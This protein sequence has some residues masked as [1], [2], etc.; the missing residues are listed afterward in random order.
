MSVVHD[1]RSPLAAIHSGAQILNGPQLPEEQV[2]R[3]ARNMYNASIRIQE[4]LQDYLEL[5][6]ASES[7]RLPSN[8][9]GL[10]ADAVRRIAD[11]AEAQSVAVV[12]DVG[13]DL[14]VTVERVRIGSVLANLLVNALEAM[15]AGGSIHIS[16]AIAEHSL[17][18]QIDRVA[19]RPKQVAA[20]EAHCRPAKG[21]VVTRVLDTG[22]GIAPEIRDRLFQP[23][24]T[25]RKPNGWGLGLAQARQVVTD[26]GGQIWLES[27]SSVGTC[28]AFSLPAS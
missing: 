24:A 2:R 19:N 15:P 4:M 1:L 14:F 21:F 26:H 23:F 13:P 6:R 22:P 5:C 11:G 18:T 10:V 9:Q 27:S 16:A 12:Q 25:A 3:L 17:E 7:R 20:P 28:F 8:L